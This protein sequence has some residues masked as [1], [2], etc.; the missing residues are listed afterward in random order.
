MTLAALTPQ[1][2]FRTFLIRVSS[3][4]SFS[5][6]EWSC[7]FSSSRYD[8][9][10]ISPKG[11]RWSPLSGVTSRVSTMQSSSFPQMDTVPSSQ[12]TPTKPV[13]NR[14]EISRRSRRS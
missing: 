1:T 10:S 11:L 5:R 12:S 6:P 4:I 2:E 3:S 8:P 7:F 9:I 13:Q 14:E